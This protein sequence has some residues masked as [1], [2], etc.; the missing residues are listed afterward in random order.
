MR[1]LRRMQSSLRNELDN[2]MRETPAKPAAP[3]QPE[4]GEPQPG[5]SEP[6]H[7]DSATDDGFAGPR[8]SFL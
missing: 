3:G 4:L 5:P 1:E 8:D 6:D 2:A 7:T